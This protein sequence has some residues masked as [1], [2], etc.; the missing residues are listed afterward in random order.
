MPVEDGND[1]SRRP[2][3]TYVEAYGGGYD[4]FVRNATVRPD[5]RIIVPPGTRSR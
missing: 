4:G 1:M 2:V 5:G 3:A